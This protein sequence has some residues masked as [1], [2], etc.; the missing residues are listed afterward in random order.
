[1]DKFNYIL[2][3]FLLVLL[4]F[5][6]TSQVVATES[7]ASQEY[8]LLESSHPLDCASFQSPDVQNPRSYAELGGFSNPISLTQALRVQW[9]QLV[10]SQSF[11]K[12]LI[13]QLAMRLVCLTK[14]R[15]GLCD[16]S[17]FYRYFPVN[18][19]YVF[20]LKRILI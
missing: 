10:L 12:S 17:P 20:T 19:Y 1:M 2:V 11:L 5:I 7:C 4:L 18:H 3:F 15:I 16:L 8:C 14:L 13:H 9:S 6:G